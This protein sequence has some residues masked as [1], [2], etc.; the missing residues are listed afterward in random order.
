MGIP[1]GHLE[2]IVEQDAWDYNTVIHIAG[3][4]I[5]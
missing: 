4:A 3:E 1:K 5:V 2:M